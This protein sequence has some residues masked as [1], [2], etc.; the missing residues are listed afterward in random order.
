MYST[1]S[2]TSDAFRISRKVWGSAIE[3][4]ILAACT[5]FAHA[6]FAR[7]SSSVCGITSLCGI[8]SWHRAIPGLL[9]IDSYYAPTKAYTAVIKQTNND[10]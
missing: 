6:I 10:S 8:A 1:S 9:Y 2:S 4:H 5:T 3:N 7:T